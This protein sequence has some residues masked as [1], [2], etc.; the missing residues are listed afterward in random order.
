MTCSIDDLAL[1]TV[2][3][4]YKFISAGTGAINSCRN[5]LKG[6]C[7][8]MPG[9]TLQRKGCREGKKAIAI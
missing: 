4:A 9:H 1:N 3:V 6:L 5:Q 8:S 2:E 7:N